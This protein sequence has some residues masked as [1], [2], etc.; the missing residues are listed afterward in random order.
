VL[1]LFRIGCAL[2]VIAALAVAAVVALGHRKLEDE[3]H[4]QWPARLGTVLTAPNRYHAREATAAAKATDERLDRLRMKQEERVAAEQWLAAQLRRGDGAITPA[5][6]SLARHADEIAAVRSFVLAHPG[7]ITWEV[8]DDLTD[9]ARTVPLTNVSLALA[10]DA[11]L[12]RAEPVAWDDAHVIEIFARSLWR[13]PSLWSEANAVKLARWAN[14]VE[15][16]LAP[17]VPSWRHDVETFDAHSR[18]LAATQY[19]AWFSWQMSRPTVEPA[20]FVATE[21]EHA[22]DAADLFVSTGGCTP[23]NSE[24]YDVLAYDIEREATANVL[25]IKEGRPIAAGTHC[26]GSWSYANGTLSRTGRLPDELK[27]LV[28]LPLRVAR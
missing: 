4:A 7:E 14:A 13:Q 18:Y 6:Q 8:G 28:P 26:D 17:P 11:L 19:N 20:L 24:Q 1:A 27:L 2:L 5:P 25:A 15:L 9:I 3:L 21:L 23:A 22:R 10:A 12:H 16:R